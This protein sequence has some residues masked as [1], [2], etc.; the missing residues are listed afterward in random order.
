MCKWSDKKESPWECFKVYRPLEAT[1]LTLNSQFQI[2]Q[3]FFRFSFLLSLIFCFDFAETCRLIFSCQF[4]WWKM[5]HRFMITHF[6]NTF[7][8]PAHPPKQRHL[9]CWTSFLNC[10]KFHIYGNKAKAGGAMGSIF[11]E[12]DIR[13]ETFVQAVKLIPTQIWNHLHFWSYI[14]VL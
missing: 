5:C 2:K 3:W 11:E 7:P 12:C 9:I 10:N 1:K 14:M 13:W 6:T 4:L 8:S